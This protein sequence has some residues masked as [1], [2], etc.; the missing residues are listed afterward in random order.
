MRGGCSSSRREDANRDSGAETVTFDVERVWKGSASKRFHSM[1]HRV[2]VACRRAS[3]SI[4][5]RIVIRCALT[6]G[7]VPQLDGLLESGQHMPDG[8]RQTLS[9]CGQGAN[10]HLTV[11]RKNAL[12]AY[13]G[14]SAVRTKNA[15]GG[16]TGSFDVE[17]VPDETGAIPQP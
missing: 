2:S 13:P 9:F 5:R 10:A 1:F 14:A 6:P 7:A 11:T 12:P 3:A 15:F 16:S 17:N 8:I 4:E